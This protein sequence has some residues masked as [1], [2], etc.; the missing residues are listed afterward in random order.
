MPNAVS[1]ACVIRSRV[2]QDPGGGGELVQ[3][4]GVVVGGGGGL[5][6]VAF[7][8]GLGAFLVE[9]GVA[10]AVGGGCGVGRV[11]GCFQFGDQAAFGRVDPVE[12]GVQVGDLA[13]LGFGVA[14]GGGGELGGEEFGAV[15]AE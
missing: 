11:G 8:F 1:R 6:G 7:G 12:L 2:G 9:L 14:G 13:G 5:E 4:G 15:V 10:G 3:Q